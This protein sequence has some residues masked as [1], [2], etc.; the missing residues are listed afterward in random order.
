MGS[1]GNAGSSLPGHPGPGNFICNIWA[2]KMFVSFDLTVLF[3]GMSLKKLFNPQTFSVQSCWKQLN[4]KRKGPEEP[5]HLKNVA[6]ET[7]VYWGTHVSHEHS[8]SGKHTVPKGIKQ[9]KY[10][11]YRFVTSSETLEGYLY[12]TKSRRNKT[13]RANKASM[14]VEGKWQFQHCHFNRKCVLFWPHWSEIVSGLG[15]FGGRGKHPAKGV[16]RPCW[17]HG[18]FIW[19]VLWSC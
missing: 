16:V 3:L 1:E 6:E 19:M 4:W 10:C 17:P 13:E 8:A 9:K 14:L 12:R 5:P 11:I 15:C 18:V 2:I 7:V